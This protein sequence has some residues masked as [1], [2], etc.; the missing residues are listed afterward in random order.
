MSRDRFNEFQSKSGAGREQYE[1]NE[2]HSINV[3]QHNGKISDQQFFQMNDSIKDEIKQLEGEISNVNRL[4]DQALSKINDQQYNQTRA[5]LD[6]ANNQVDQTIMKIRADLIEMKGACEDPSLSRTKI[7]SRIGRHQSLAKNFSV[8]I[9]RYQQVKHE[10]WSKSKMRLKRQYLIARPDA[11]ENEV[12]AAIESD[13]ANN[14]FTQAI[15]KSNRAGDARRV[16]KEVEDRHTDIISLE[17]TIQQLSSLF[18]EIGQMINQQ[19][20]AID[21][22]ESMVED[23]HENVQVAVGE[24]DKAIVYR[25][26]SRK[27]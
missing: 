25:K 15:M 1:Y 12:E 3:S 22:I 17:Q 16:L 6:G 24:V 21:S 7:V 23:T 13:Q 2:M 20:E 26:S 4:C 10:F 27:A 11:T 19:Q 5:E 8:V 9:S 14:I 18:E